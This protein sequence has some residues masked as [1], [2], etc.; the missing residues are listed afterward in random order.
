MN[1][2]ECQTVFFSSRTTISIP[3]CFKTNQNHP[4]T[5]L[6]QLMVGAL[7]YEV[8]PTDRMTFESHE[9]KSNAGRNGTYS[10]MGWLVIMIVLVTSS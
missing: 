10:R 1:L 7:L 5:L 4:L 2:L 8:K 9:N 3:Y 6:R